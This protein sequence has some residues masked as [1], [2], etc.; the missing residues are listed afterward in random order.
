MMIT[1]DMLRTLRAAAIAAH[2]AGKQSGA[3]P[4]SPQ[5]EV[6]DL[7]AGND[8]AMLWWQLPRRLWDAA[9]DA[10]CTG[11]IN[12]ESDSDLYLHPLAIREMDGAY[13]M[14]EVK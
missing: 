2:D 7:L 8:G 14:P 4:S 6:L 13:S 11:I 10:V 1:K 5:Q 3:A 12:A 9:A